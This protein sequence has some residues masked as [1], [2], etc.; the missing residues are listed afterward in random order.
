MDVKEIVDIVVSGL[1]H[2]A[3]EVLILPLL[4]TGLAIILKC[5]ARSGASARL[6]VT[7]DDA[8][9]GFELG[10][11]ACLTLVAATPRAAETYRSLQDQ[12]REST[13][14]G[15]PT[16]DVL[17]AKADSALQF[18]IAAPMFTFLALVLLLGLS[19]VLGQKGWKPGAPGTAATIHWGWVT[20]ADLAGLLFLAGALG[21][22]GLIR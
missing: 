7:A 4:V 13:K 18:L 19:L 14:L 17:S 22:G 5:L 20:G 6:N 15:Q 12:I 16:I 8:L 1:K 10:V 9:V 3:F 21:L 2:P 11:T